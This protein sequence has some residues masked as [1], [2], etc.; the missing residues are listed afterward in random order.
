MP[1][2]P[3]YSGDHPTLYTQT[4]VGQS[5]WFGLPILIKPDVDY[6]RKQLRAELDEMG[7]EYRP[8]VAGNF[9]NQD[10]L[11]H[12]QIVCNDNLEN[13]SWLQTH[14]L[15]IGN[16]HYDVTDILIGLSDIGRGI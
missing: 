9:A 10:A 11:R 16:H 8:I 4:E 2:V 7:F 14:G 1:G 5:S 12:M 15:F 13:A 6:D 3:R